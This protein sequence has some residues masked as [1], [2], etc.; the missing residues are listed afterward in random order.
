MITQ[1]KTKQ[2]SVSVLAIALCLL[3]AGPKLE[4][5]DEPRNMMWLGGAAPS[6][7]GWSQ[8]RA[9]LQGPPY[10]YD[11]NEVLDTDFYNPTLGV[12]G[13]KDLLLQNVT[14][15]EVDDVLCVAHDYGAIIGRYAQLETDQISAMIFVGAPHQGS[16][17]VDELARSG[18]SGANSVNI[19]VENALAVAGEDGCADCGIAE[20]LRDWVASFQSA[21]S[22]LADISY[23]DDLIKNINETPPT[24]PYINIIG[25]KVPKTD[26]SFLGMLDSRMP[27]GNDLFLTDCFIEL[28]N[29][30]R[31]NLDISKQ[32][33]IWSSL[34]GAFRRIA[35]AIDRIVREFGEGDLLSINDAV[36]SLIRDDLRSMSSAIWAADDIQDETAKL[37]RC[38]LALNYI[39]VGLNGF[40]TI[41][42]KGA[43]VSTEEVVEDYRICM[44]ECGVDMAWGDWPDNISCDEYCWDLYGPGGTPVTQTVYEY[45]FSGHDWVY[46]VPEQSLESSEK[47]ADI[48]INANHFQETQPPFIVP[49]LADI[50]DG[51]YGTAFEVPKQ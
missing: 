11:Y 24:V 35:I 41:G 18:A 31:S 28:K 6:S 12:V 46:T 20:Q 48:V 32:A 1:V 36:N 38:N 37:L 23:D 43:V 40:L 44:V 14:A 50:F 2:F 8:T 13:A 26:I 47:V 51:A 5:Q 19:M 29:E 45:E 16:R 22:Y 25:N 33:A 4:A 34:N 27:S 39:A 21:S 10:F 9:T 3:I 7:S 15:K 17:F 42:G 30:A 49:E